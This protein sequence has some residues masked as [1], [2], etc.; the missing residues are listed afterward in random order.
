MYKA[1]SNTLNNWFI[2]LFAWL[3]KCEDL[4]SKNNLKNYDIKRISGFLE[5]RYASFWFKKYS[6]F[7]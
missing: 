1:K 4:F 6:N 2:K 5:E 3:N 7:K